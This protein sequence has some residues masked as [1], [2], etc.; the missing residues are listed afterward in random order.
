[1]GY[2]VALGCLGHD[3]IS[4]LVKAVMRLITIIHYVRR[5]EIQFEPIA[6]SCRFET[7]SEIY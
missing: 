7:N 2:K 1:M 6:P 4:F 3:T 5:G